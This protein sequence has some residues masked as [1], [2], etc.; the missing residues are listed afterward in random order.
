MDERVTL[1]AE[2]VAE[3]RRS[4]YNA[5]VTKLIVIHEEL[6]IIR[7]VPDS[8][9]PNIEAGQYLSIGLGNWEPRAPDTQPETLAR[10]HLQKL[11]KRAYS[12]SC[13]LVF[14]DGQL[15][16]VNEYPYLE[17]YVSLVRRAARHP[18]ALTPRLFM[19][20]EGARLYISGRATGHYNLAS[21]KSDEDVFFFATGTGEAPHNAMI[22]E[23]LARSHR[24]RVVNAV[25][26][27]RHSDAAY[28]E[29]HR[30]I[31]QRYPRYSYLLLTT[32]EPEN[33]DPAKS[34]YVGK[35]YLQD[36]VRSGELEEMSGVKLTPAG[37]QV[38]LCGSPEMI[39]APKVPK[40]NLIAA[41]LANSMLE[42]LIGRGF[43]ANRSSPTGNVHFEDYW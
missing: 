12:V 29:N 31:A 10:E 39:G 33:V 8:G 38:F 13:S 32:R 7:V 24:G 28:R 36:V 41:P 37:T 11:C 26:V 34:D 35:K 27:R 18:P 4:H 19:V 23:L 40:E 5:T 2:T 1:P 20:D 6:R 42:V 3:L 14:K 22:A 9:V 30:E 21:V 43:Q 17:F 16:R 15:L 25:C